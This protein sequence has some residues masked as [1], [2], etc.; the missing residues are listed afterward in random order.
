MK[1]IIHLLKHNERNKNGKLINKLANL[2]LIITTNWTA[3]T[4]IPNEEEFN[5]NVIEIFQCVSVHKNAVSFNSMI[6]LNTFL[7]KVLLH[8]PAKVISGNLF[9]Y[10]C[11]LL[12]SSLQL[13]SKQMTLIRDP[14]LP[15]TLEKRL[16]TSNMFIL[17]SMLRLCPDQHGKFLNIL[18]E[19]E[20][21]QQIFNLML[22]LINGN[23]HLDLAQNLP[24][25]FV[26]LSYYPIGAELL[27]NLNIIHNFYVCFNFSTE[28]FTSKTDDP[29]SS[30]IKTIFSLLIRTTINM[31][32]HLNHHFIDSCVSFVAVYVDVF[33]VICKSFRQTPKIKNARLVLLMFE[34]CS[35]L[36]KYTK[37]WNT[38]HP[39]SLNVATEEILLTSNSVIAFILRPNI[40]AQSLDDL[41]NSNQRKLPGTADFS[42][43]PMFEEFQDLLIQILTHSLMFVIDVSPKL[44]E[45]FEFP[46]SITEKYNLLISTNF[47]IPNI[48]SVEILTFGSIINLINFI[49]KSIY[50]V[51][52]FEFDFD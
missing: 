21:S 40:V 47:S 8:K 4:V 12:N 5:Q 31:L 16:I 25:F 42:K 27:Y 50:K 46:E 18:R 28:L 17:V 29:Q 44:F 30:Y 33:K 38:H 39:I 48:D 23:L 24:S 19:N 49:I 7:L 1:N 6:S 13:F 11:G 15:L 51:R 37:I 20:I 43:I 10:V 35:T 14:K 26:T 32:I 9:E 41:P 22:H 2:L 45:L 34:L 52:V 36:S 3:A